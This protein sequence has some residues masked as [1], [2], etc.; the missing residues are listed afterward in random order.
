MLRKWLFPIAL[1]V[2][3]FFT[4]PST[5]LAQAGPTP[6]PIG[7]NISATFNQSTTG[8][9]NLSYNGTSSGSP[10]LYTNG[11]NYCA[12][13]FL[14]SMTA[15]GANVRVYG[16][17]DYAPT[18][19][20]QTQFGTSGVI[21]ATAGASFGAYAVGPTTSA[22]AQIKLNIQS[23]TS[24]ALTGTIVCSTAGAGGSSGGSVTFPYQMT[25]G[26]TATAGSGL[27]ALGTY[28]TTAPTLTNAQV[29]ALQLD[30][31]GNLKV[32]ITAGGSAANYSM[33]NAGQTAVAGS[34][35]GNV[36]AYNTTPVTLTNGQVGACQF[37][38]LGNLRVNIASTQALY[39]MTSGQLAV[40]NSAFG[41]AGIYNS[42][43]PT[44]TNAQ[45]AA[46]QLDA[47]GNLKVNVVS[48]GS[49]YPYSMSGS[50]VT[51]TAASGAGQLCTYNSSPITTTNGYAAPCQADV[52]GYQKV[53]VAT[54]SI[55]TSYPYSMVGGGVTATTASGAGILC[56]YNA[57]GVTPTS[58]YAVP[59]QV[60]GAGSINVNVTNPVLTTT[61]YYY[62]N[63]AAT[64]QLIKSSGGSLYGFGVDNN[65]GAVAWVQLF[66][67]ASCSSVTLGTTTPSSVQYIATPGS[68][69]LDELSPTN[70]WTFTNG[71]CI[72]ATTTPTGS[73]G[74]AAGLYVKALY[75]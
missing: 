50:G 39:N 10:W 28:N 75:K 25:S 44:L 32:N 73:T 30:A 20:L 36:C 66:D 51:A 71:M 7:N 12:I 14:S 65:S 43:A 23:I 62:A 29:G 67:V 11:Q 68:N 1:G 22:L 9:V 60:N 13:T 64:G 69:F 42:T 58:G 63:L 8:D 26:Q 34:A 27:G 4:H 3:A 16:A 5:A 24:G 21:A 59:C 33:T 35:Y 40:A 46:L 61:H 45:V 41:A 31:S 6:P 54:G 52:N 56:T 72:F 37:D 70:G 57:S 74:A 38:N 15:V 47:S 53:D 48:G 17:N 55:T 19:V 2:A 18:Q 49:S